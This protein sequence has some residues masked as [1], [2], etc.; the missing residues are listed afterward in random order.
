MTNLIEPHKTWQIKDASKLNDFMTCNRLYFYN[1]ILGWKSESPNNHLHFGTAMHIAL[2]H[3]ALNGYGEDA[4]LGAYEKLLSEYRLEFAPETDEIFHPKTPDNAAIVLAKYT[5]EYADDL[6]KY[7]VL[8][9]EIA[10]SVSIREDRDL[11]FRMDTILE[12]QAG[13]KFSLEHKTASGYWN[14]AEQWPLAFQV[15]TYNHVLYCMYG[16]QEVE[17]VTMNG[18][19]FK[20]AKKA[21]EQLT[22]GVPL[23]VQPPYEF[24]RVKIRKNPSQMQQWLSQAN[25]LFTQIEQETEMLMDSIEEDKVLD[26]F[27]LNTTQCIRYGRVCEFN[28]YC[29]AWSNPLRKC[30]EPPI[31]FKVDFWDPTEREARHTFDLKGGKAEWVKKESSGSGYGQ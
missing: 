4:I 7:K 12:D 22:M 3:L 2:E 1:H 6:D 24:M 28:D 21:W 14:W 29:L 19:A 26:A 27:P 30:G 25:T 18:L 10:G 16:A 23:T 20:K 17:G 15:G 5:Q 8:F 11:Y 13:K 31:G 9:T